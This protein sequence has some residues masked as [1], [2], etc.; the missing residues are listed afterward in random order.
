M[1]ILIWYIWQDV[2]VVLGSRSAKLVKISQSQWL[3]R[4]LEISSRILFGQKQVERQNLILTILISALE[5]SSFKVTTS[6]LSHFLVSHN[7]CPLC[8]KKGTTL[9]L[10]VLGVGQLCFIQPAGSHTSACFS[11]A[12]GG[13]WRYPFFFLLFKFLLQFFGSAQNFSVLVT[14]RQLLG[15]LV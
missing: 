4:S 2:N 11:K 14:G 3:Q 7:S 5:S 8:L 12:T 15:Y 6:V 10:P 1:H 9:V 13:S